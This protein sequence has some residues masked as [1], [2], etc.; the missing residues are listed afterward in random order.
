MKKLKTIPCKAKKY[1][2]WEENYVEYN[3]IEVIQKISAF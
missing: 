3:H 1:M 2:M